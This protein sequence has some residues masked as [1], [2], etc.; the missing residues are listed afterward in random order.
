MMRRCSILVFAPLLVAAQQGT[1]EEPAAGVLASVTGTV[2]LTYPDGHKG[3]AQGFDWLKPRTRIETNAGGSVLVVLVNGARY[4][5]GERS[6]AT[7][8]KSTLRTVA[9]NVR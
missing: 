4:E 3:R 8:E 9:G 2:T 1:A 7:I 6:R 5:V